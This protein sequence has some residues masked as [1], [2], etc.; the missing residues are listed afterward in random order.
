M[1][2]PNS[3]VYKVL[4]GRFFMRTDPFK[5]S[6]SSNASFLWKSLCADREIV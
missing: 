4:K 2:R 1:S 6:L 5:V 3:L